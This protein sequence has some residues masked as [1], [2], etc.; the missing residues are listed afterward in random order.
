MK[1]LHKLTSIL[2]LLI[3]AIFGCEKNPAA[4]DPIEKL[5]VSAFL[6]GNKTLRKERAIFLSYTSA[7]DKLYKV[8]DYAVTD[9]K[10]TITHIEGSKTYDLVHNN[11]KPGNWYNEALIPIPKNTYHLR[12][13]TNRDT[14]IAMTKIPPAITIHTELKLFTYDQPDT[15]FEDHSNLSSRKPILIEC[16]EPEVVVLEDAFCHEYWEDAKYVQEL[17]GQEGPHSRNDYDQGINREPRHI[18]DGGRLIDYKIDPNTGYFIQDWYSSMI[19]FYGTTTVQIIALDDNYHN[20]VFSDVK[21]W[22]SGIVG[23][24]GVFGSVTG[25]KFIF[26]ISPE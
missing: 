21:E 16:A 5:N 24:V 17:F 25:E 10:V 6:W 8:N 4:P 11:E 1:S 18:I 19:W 13:E 14:V 20:Y 26:E 3:I 7:V 23:G 2:L 12:V 15:N 22:T 9:A